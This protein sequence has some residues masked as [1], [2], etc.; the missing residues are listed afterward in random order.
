MS[1][2]RIDSPLVGLGFYVASLMVMALISVLVKLLADQYPVSQVLLFRFAFSVIPLFGFML[3]TAGISSMRTSRIRDHAIRSVSG[4]ISVSLFFYAIALLPLAEATMI[5]YSSPIF[6]TMLSIVVLAEYIGVRRWF[7][8]ILGFAG[9]IIITQPGGELFGLGSIFAL[10]SAMAAAF[11]VV[12]LRLLSDTESPI[13]T[14][15]IYNAMGM[16]VFATWTMLSGWVPVQ[17]GIHWLLLVAVGL[18]ASF[19]QFFF[20]VAFK[21]SEASMLAP[22]E[23]LILV[24]ATIAGYLIWDEIPGTSSMI[25]AAFIVASGFVIIVRS[26][27]LKNQF[28]VSR[29]I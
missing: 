29:R 7:A 3:L 5:S 18:L 16:L 23:Y 17:S 19:Q 28:A 6:I 9:V 14:S 27:R 12:W 1:T 10:G 21:Y 4:I 2:K 25:G 24:F 11:V 13:T 26:R 8:V 22:F 20:A 15:I